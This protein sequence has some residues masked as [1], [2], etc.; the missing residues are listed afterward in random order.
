MLALNG[1][2]LD[3]LNINA[4]HFDGFFRKG[5][6]KVLFI[7]CGYVIEVRIG[8]HESPHQNL[9]DRFLMFQKHFFVH[10][11]NLFLGLCQNLLGINGDPTD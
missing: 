7:P 8:S 11:V 9:K 5:M 4:S 1:V 2:S 10:L 3:V 6:P